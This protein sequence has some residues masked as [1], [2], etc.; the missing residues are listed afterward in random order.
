MTHGRLIIGIEKDRASIQCIHY[1]QPSGYSVRSQGYCY[2]NK[3]EKRGY[4]NHDSHYIT[5][6][7]CHHEKMRYHKQSEELCTYVGEGR[8]VMIQHNMK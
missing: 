5:G 3:Q 8:G 4:V 7:G 6:A 2:K 1:K